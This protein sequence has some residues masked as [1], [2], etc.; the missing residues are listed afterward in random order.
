MFVTIQYFCFRWKMIKISNYRLRT[1]CAVLVPLKNFSSICRMAFF[2]RCMLL[3]ELT[4]AAFTC[5]CRQRSRLLVS[6]RLTTVVPLPLVVLL[7]L[8][9]LDRDILDVPA[10]LLLVSEGPVPDTSLSPPVHSNELK[11]DSEECV[12]EEDGI[13]S[14]SSKVMLSS[15][16]DSSESDNSSSFPSDKSIALILLNRKNST[17]HENK[18][19]RNSQ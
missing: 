6:T 10:A 12:G 9:F 8:R 7:R 3:I 13:R 5:C 14:D 17:T 15:R 18:S 16:S 1:S 4:K 2:W 19:N 11:P